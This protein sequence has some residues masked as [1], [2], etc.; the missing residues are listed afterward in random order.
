[1]TKVHDKTTSPGRRTANAEEKNCPGLLHGKTRKNAKPPLLKAAAAKR[2]EPEE[3]EPSLLK[4]HS[5][6]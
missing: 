6:T 3:G 2:G 4:R 5:K 1:M